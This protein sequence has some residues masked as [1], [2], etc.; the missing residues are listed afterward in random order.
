M[1]PEE[2]ELSY[3]ATTTGEAI[4][5]SS[6]GGEEDTCNRGEEDSSTGK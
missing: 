1:G 6:E 4:I 2:P 5:V 3:S